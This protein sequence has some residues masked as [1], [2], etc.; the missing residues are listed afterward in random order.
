MITEY[1][2]V[3]IARNLFSISRGIDPYSLTTWKAH[4]SAEIISADRMH[5]GCIPHAWFEIKCMKGIPESHS[6]RVCL[7]DLNFQAVKLA[8]SDTLCRILRAVFQDMH[9]DNWV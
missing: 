6:T 3:C 5:I 4:K 1:D 9:E 7:N 8:L 2:R